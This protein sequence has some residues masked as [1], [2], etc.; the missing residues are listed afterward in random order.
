MNRQFN[1]HSSWTAIGL[2]IVALCP[3][4]AVADSLWRDDSPINMLGDKRARAVGDILTI[5][6][7]ESVASAKDNNTSTA[8]KASLNSS[9]DSFFYPPN[10]AA[11]AISRFLT[12]G[13]VYPSMKLNSDN[14][15]SGG[16][17]ISNSEQITARV[18]VR[19][20]DVLPNGNLVIEGRRVTEFASEKQNVVLRGVV[21]SEDITPYNTVYSYNVADVTI[22]M[23]QNG[24]VTDSQRKGWFFRVWEKVSPF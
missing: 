3:W 21:R 15:F 20:V 8:R 5:I 11:S 10:T 17:T 12:K 7:Q 22:S 24:T 16:G 9:M 6:V 23:Q 4:Q 14:Q 2:L 18:T 13:G 19:V 1:F